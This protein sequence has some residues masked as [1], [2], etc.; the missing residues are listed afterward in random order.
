MAHLIGGPTVRGAPFGCQ[1]HSAEAFGILQFLRNVGK[2]LR[3]RAQF[4]WHPE[5]CFTAADDR[6]GIGVGVVALAR[7]TQGRALSVGPRTIAL[8]KWRHARVVL[9]QAALPIAFAGRE[10]IR[11]GWAQEIPAEDA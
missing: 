11:I 5:R 1:L 4:I 9:V 8:P 3:D 2:Y 6:A 7:L 10:A